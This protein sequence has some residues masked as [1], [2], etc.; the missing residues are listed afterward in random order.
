MN[1]SRFPSPGDLPKP[2]IKPVSPTLAG[3]FFTTEPA[4][5]P[6]TVVLTPFQ[7]PPRAPHCSLVKT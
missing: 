2:G 1:W 3:A 7:K 5:K 4:G 6:M